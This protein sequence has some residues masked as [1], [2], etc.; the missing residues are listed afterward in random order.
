MRSGKEENPM[1]NTSMSLEAS[2]TS[3]LTENKEE[4]WTPRVMK[5]FFLATPQTAEPTESLTTGPEQ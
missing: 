2:V 4:N 1:S 3:W 5:G